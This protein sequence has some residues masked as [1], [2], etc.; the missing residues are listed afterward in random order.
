MSISEKFQGFLSNLRIT[1]DDQISLRYGEI[2]AALNKEFR[3][4]ESKTA[5]NLY[6][7]SPQVV[8]KALLLHLSSARLHSYI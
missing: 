1:N 2:T 3:D 5:N 6:G 7:L 4:T 8:S